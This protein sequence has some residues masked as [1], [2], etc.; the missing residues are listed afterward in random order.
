[1]EETET[2]EERR[3]RILDECIEIEKTHGTALALEHAKLQG[4]IK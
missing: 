4:C 1:M 3:G 2:E